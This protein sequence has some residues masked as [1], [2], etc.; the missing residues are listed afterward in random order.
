MTRI[1][2]RDGS[3]AWFDGVKDAMKYY[4]DPGKYDPS[5]KKDDI[6]SLNVTEYYG[7][8]VI[9]GATAWYVSGSDVL[10]PMGRE[11]I[12]LRSEAEALDFMRDHKGKR[13]IR[14]DE[15]TPTTVKGVDR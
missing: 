5:R 11:L 15:I 13:V 7:L 2:F 3:H 14:F 10:G 9:D 12:P 6:K 8:T 4:F 1:D